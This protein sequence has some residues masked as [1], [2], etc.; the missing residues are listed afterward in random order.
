[1]GEQP[2][3]LTFS[4]DISEEAARLE[5]PLLVVHRRGD[6]AIH[7]IAGEALAALAPHAEP[8]ALAGDSHMAWFGDSD[9]VLGAIAPFLGIAA[10]ARRSGGAVEELTARKREVRRA[11]QGSELAI[12]AT[13]GA[14]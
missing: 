5:T 8:V 4:I 11:R 7:F 13:L 12:V 9:D 3:D 14:A 6:R 10:P 2:L 1:V